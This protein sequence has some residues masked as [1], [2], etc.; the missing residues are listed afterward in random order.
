MVSGLV[1]TLS[2]DTHARDHAI[3]RISAHPAINVAPMKECWLPIAVEARDRNESRDIHH[4]LMTLDGVDR[5]DVISINC[6]PE[7]EISLVGLER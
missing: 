7:E 5:V 1:V 6:C 2:N 4:W 3:A